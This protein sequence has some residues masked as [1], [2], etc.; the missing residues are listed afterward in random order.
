MSATSKI[1]AFNKRTQLKILRTFRGTALSMFSKIV[2]RT[3]VDTGRA[4]SN[5]QSSLNTPS[6]GID[7]TGEGYSATVASAKLG[8]SIFFI[9]NLPY[10]R[11]LEDGS[12]THKPVGMV[13]VT[14]AEFESIASKEIRR[15]K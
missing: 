3:P 5:W 2:S 11:V 9:N 8:D 10:I 4:R 13:K 1:A 7:P 12:R 15:N 14:I 6:L